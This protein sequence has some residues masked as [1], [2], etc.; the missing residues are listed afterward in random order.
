MVLSP[1]LITYLG[2]FYFLLSNYI[3]ATWGKGH[4]YIVFT[5]HNIERNMD[6]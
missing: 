4:S 3:L 2:A 6:S 5:F 1:K